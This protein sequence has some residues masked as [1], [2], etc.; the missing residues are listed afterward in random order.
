MEV[1]IRRMIVPIV[2]RCSRQTCL[3]RIDR[4]QLVDDERTADDVY[5]SVARLVADWPREAGVQ[6][7]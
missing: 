1:R 4:R 2:L 5:T 6:P 7:G 3:E